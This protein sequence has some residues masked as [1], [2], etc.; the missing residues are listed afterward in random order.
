MKGGMAPTERIKFGRKVRQRCT[1]FG[2]EGMKRFIN[3]GVFVCVFV[4]VCAR[5]GLS[6]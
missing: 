6:G 5:M 2:A 1:S 3:G 4:H